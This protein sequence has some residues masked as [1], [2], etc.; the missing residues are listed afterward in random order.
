MKMLKVIER[1]RSVREYKEKA[2][3]SQDMQAVMGF[4]D[5]YPKLSDKA[6]VEFMLLENGGDVAKKLEGVAGYSGVMI[7]APH[8][9]LVLASVNEAA[10]KSAGYAGEFV[11]LNV[12]KHDIGTCW[13]DGTKKS[14]EIKSRLALE[15]NKVVVGLIA[16][17]YAKHEPRLSR[18]YD[19][20]P[21]GSA[22]PL[23]DMGYP[24]IDS[25]YSKEPVSNRLS[26]EEISYLKKW[27]AN[28]SSD[29]LQKRGY[30]QVFYYMRMA[31]SWGNRQPWRFIL[32]GSKIVLVMERDERVS[33]YS[34]E[35][36][37]GIAMLYF[38]VAMHDVG[39]PGSWKTDSLEDTDKYDIPENH[40]VGGY[41]TF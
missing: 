21:D 37:A 5:T 15:S 34:E 1:R 29:E 22:S 7:K 38:E 31:P 16:F 39:L 41:Y 36:E 17:G 13:I 33:D 27:G 40:F 28:V 20:D 18:I 24:N 14:D 25:S 26:I 6:E 32:D 19:T 30:D 23:T 4:C 2:V 3:S 10:Y 11:I 8:Y 35:V 12:T 9:L